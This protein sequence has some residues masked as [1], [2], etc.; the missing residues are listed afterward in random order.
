M[1]VDS[2]DLSRPVFACD[3]RDEGD[4]LMM[5]LIKE[6]FVHVRLCLV[7]AGCDADAVCDGLGVEWRDYQRWDWWILD[8]ERSQPMTPHARRNNLIRLAMIAELLVGK[9]VEKDWT[10]TGGLRAPGGEC[11]NMGA[12][13]GVL[14]D[15]YEP[16]F[17]PAEPWWGMQAMMS[18]AFI[19]EVKIAFG[20]D[21][22][23]VPREDVVA[24]AR[25]WQLLFYVGNHVDTHLPE[26]PDVMFALLKHFVSG[27]PHSDYPGLKEHYRCSVEV[28]CTLPGVLNT[29]YTRHCMSSVMKYA[30]T[31]ASRGRLMGLLNRRGD[32]R[33]ASPYIEG[34]EGKKIKFF[35][36]DLTPPE[37][38]AHCLIYMLTAS[39][40]KYHAS[41]KNDLLASQGW[42]LCRLF[43][44]KY[45]NVRMNKN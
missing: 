42:L 33:S 23:N 17:D 43:A 19:S 1:N 8:E 18:P 25:V 41:F 5:R 34:I 6:V 16:P 14:S 45:P 11:L 38:I 31:A 3:G 40:A 24:Q 36:S 9:R 13:A 4:M 12:F 39:N 15:V 32:Q 35:G 20:Q 44:H 2:L 21:I 10:S 37:L 29:L 30:D 26:T 27:G 28:D 7:K 22:F